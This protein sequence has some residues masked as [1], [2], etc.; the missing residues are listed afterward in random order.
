MPKEKLPILE[1]V[2]SS[3]INAIGYTYANKHLL[4][5]FQNGNLYLY[6]Q[7][8]SEHYENMKNVDVSVGK[9]FNIQIKDRYNFSVIN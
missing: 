6:Y 3:M 9:Y 1:P 2:I 7:V 8:K 5:Q 4:I